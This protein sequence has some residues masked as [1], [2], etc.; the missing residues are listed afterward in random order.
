LVIT[1]KGYAD[2]S[3]IEEGSN[4]YKK[5]EDRMRLSGKQPLSNADLNQELS[6]ARA[7]SVIELLKTFTVGKSADGNTIKNILYLYEGKGEKF[8]NPKITDYSI[9]D[10]RRRIVLL[11]WSIFPD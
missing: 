10:P 6:N 5:I 8:P 2:A 4:L 3:T 7:Q 1:A 9:A 11:F